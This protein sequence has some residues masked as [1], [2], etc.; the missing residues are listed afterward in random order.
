[1]RYAFFALGAVILGVGLGLITTQAEMARD[2]DVLPPMSYSSAEWV[3]TRGRSSLS[4]QSEIGDHPRVEVEGGEEFDFGNMEQGEGSEHTFVVKNVGTQPLDIKKGKTTCKCIMSKLDDGMLPPGGTRTV[5]LKWTA[6]VN[7]DF[8]KSYEQSAEILTND[9]DRP[10]VRVKVRGKVSRTIEVSPPAVLLGSFTTE[11]PVTRQLTLV[12]NRH[13]KYTI[14]QP[15]IA[16]ADWRDHFDISFSSLNS[17]EPSA[18]EPSRYLITVTTKSSMPRGRV[19]QYLK[20]KTSYPNIPEVEI[21]IEG[22]VQGDVVVS[23]SKVVANGDLRFGS[24]ASAQGVKTVVLLTAR[25]EWVQKLNVSVAECFPADAVKF[26]LK[27]PTSR[28][29]STALWTIRLTIPPGTA[30]IDMLGPTKENMGRLVIKT[31]HPD[32]SEIVVPLSFAVVNE[33]ATSEN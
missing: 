18:F 14:E 8:E 7:T 25:G 16:D 19:N 6:K 2:R 5:T 32:V 1:M 29:G 3:K 22:T 33:A 20:I 23:G 24:I 30:P 10:M 15:Y 17:K 11:T 28:T 31:N 27:E 12:F 26:E 4:S 13:G 21:P 9:P